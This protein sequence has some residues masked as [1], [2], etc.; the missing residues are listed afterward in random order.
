MQTNRETME[1]LTALFK[2]LSDRNRLRV[3]SALMQK[4]ELCACHITELLQVTGATASR[5]M[6]VLIAAGLVE[7]RKDGRWVHYRF[8]RERSDLKVLVHWLETRFT[9]DYQANSDAQLVAGITSGGRVELCR[10]Q[11]DR[12]CTPDDR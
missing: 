2:A 6:G 12:T 9:C 7:S 3:I 11:R 8:R 4:E 5:H 1:T 10:R